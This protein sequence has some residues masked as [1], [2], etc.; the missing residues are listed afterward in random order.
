MKSQKYY[1]IEYLSS[2]NSVAKDNIKTYKKFFSPHV[3]QEMTVLDYG[4]GAGVLLSVINCKYK[5]GVDINENALQ[6]AKKNGINEVHLNLNSLEPNSIDL[7]VSNSALEHV[8]NPHQVLSDLY[9]ILKPNGKI[10]FRLPHE[11][12]GWSYKPGD[13][14]YHLYTWSPMAIGNLF[15][16]VGFIKI[17]VKIE[18][19]KKPPLFKF[20]R[21]IYLEQIA[22]YIYRI[23]RLVLDEFK[24]IRIGVDGYSIV[25]AQ[26]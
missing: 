5:I 8:P 18:K 21:I 24:I 22:S 23:F 20:F 1:D 13:W 6:E 7:I 17:D 16:D 10:I 12:L 14:N 26:K 3:T 25:S 11:T 9:T 19:G 2:Q 15:N 4:C